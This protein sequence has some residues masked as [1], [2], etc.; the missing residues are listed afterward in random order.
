MS[1][2]FGLMYTEYHVQTRIQCHIGPNTCKSDV[3]LVVFCHTT[4]SQE[5]EDQQSHSHLSD[6]TTPRTYHLIEDDTMYMLESHF[7]IPMIH[8][9]TSPVPFIIMAMDSSTEHLKP[10]THPQRMIHTTVSSAP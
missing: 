10:G 3:T 6:D 1:H 5:L 4:A 7:I 8:V 9:H 2:V